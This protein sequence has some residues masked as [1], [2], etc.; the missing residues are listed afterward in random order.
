MRAQI[1]RIEKL[2]ERAVLVLAASSL[3]MDMLPPLY[4][5][6]L[7]LGDTERL[8]VVFYCRGG[9]VN[10][11]RRIG[12]LL[13]EVSTHVCFI[14]PLHCESSGTIAAL[15]AHEIIAGPMAGFSPVDPHLQSEQRQDSDGAPDAI[16]AENIRLFAT[17]CQDWFGMPEREAQAQSLSA[18]C[19]AIFP[20]TLTSFYRATLETQGVCRELLARSM[21]DRSEEARAKIVDQL[22]FGYHSHTFSLT[23]R[24]LKALGLPV[25]RDGEIEKA[26]W[27]LAHEIRRSRG[28]EAPCCE[29]GER[30]SAILATRNLTRRQCRHPGASRSR[31]EACETV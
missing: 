25:R 19:A 28:A 6:L 27:K 20:T 26:A 18:L 24:D 4:D 16:A 31:W 22:L 14:V 9:L 30:V 23:Q 21:G 15:A 12:L 10:A 13:H 1:E 2:R 5:A 8:D 17:M 11:A 7:E 29:E 3:E